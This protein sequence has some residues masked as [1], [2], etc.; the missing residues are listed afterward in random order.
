VSS[1][2][3]EPIADEKSQVE[4]PTSLFKVFGAIGVFMIVLGAVY[5]YKYAVD[6]GW[7]GITGRIALGVIASLMTIG[8]G[9]IM[10]KRQ[11]V[12]FS[13]VIIACGLGLMYFTFF[14]TYHFEQ[15]RQ[16][17]GMTLLVNTTMLLA[18]MLGGMVLGIRLDARIIVYGSLIL[19]YI[20]AFLSGI[21]GDTLH[22]L[23]YI[24]LID[25]MVFAIARR[26]AWYAG[27]PAQ[28]LTYIAYM[29]WF[30]QGVYSPDSILSQTG[31]PVLV[32][33]IAL[34]AYYAIFTALSFIQSSDVKEGECITLITTAST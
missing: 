31:Y 6:Q 23:V 5:F 1:V 18:V 12:N 30:Y 29:I 15:Y 19:G 16:A 32:T 2:R 17:L 11:Y 7:I 26:K 14:A 33:F 8:A 9:L 4:T 13:Q 20:A 21:D 28:V 27:I 3:I 22:I 25:I 10:F 34:F 24:G